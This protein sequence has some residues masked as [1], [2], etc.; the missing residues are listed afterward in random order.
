VKKHSGKAEV[1]SP[2]PTRPFKAVNMT[3]FTITKKRNF[4]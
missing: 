3:E 4:W 2:L 1:L